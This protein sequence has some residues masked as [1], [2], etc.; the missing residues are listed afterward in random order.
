M[1]VLSCE[2][3]QIRSVILAEIQCEYERYNIL[4]NKTFGIFVNKSYGLKAKYTISLPL[5]SVIWTL[6]VLRA[7]TTI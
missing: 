6:I 1:R 2:V 7:I 5:A 3:S 4:Q